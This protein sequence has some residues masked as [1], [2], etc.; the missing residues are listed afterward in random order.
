MARGTNHAPVHI[1]TADE[2]AL[3]EPGPVKGKQISAETCVHFLPFD[4][5]DYEKFG[6]LIKCNPAIKTSADR[7]GIIRALAEDRINVLATDRAP[8]LPEEKGQ[9]YDQPPSGL[10]LVQFALQVA[11]QRVAEG[12]LTLEQVAEVVSHAPA[13][14]FDVK[15]RGYLREGYAADLVLVDPAKPHTLIREE[16]LSKCGWSPFERCTFDCSIAATFVKG[17]RVWDGSTV[18]DTVR[19]QRLTFPR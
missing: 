15:Q 14:R 18:D 11:L 13:T 4:D 12:Q 10:P 9:L 16:V 1:S 5:R 7:A 6:F 2:A 3:F 19:G 17:Q 8:H